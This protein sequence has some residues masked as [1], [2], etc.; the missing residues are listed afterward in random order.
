[1]AHPTAD[2]SEREQAV[3]RALASELED[4]ARV[5]SSLLAR[6][7]PPPA[8]WSSEAFAA[9]VAATRSRLSAILARGRLVTAWRAFAASRRA[10]G[11]RRDASIERLGRE[12]GA[13]AFA[14]RQLELERQVRL[15]PWVDLIRRHELIA[16]GR[17]PNLEAPIWFG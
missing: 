5:L 6:D 10:W 17:D 14:L 1:M 12:P 11:L 9:D 15:A 3:D 4:L 7:E 16:I 13:V 8:R 2:R